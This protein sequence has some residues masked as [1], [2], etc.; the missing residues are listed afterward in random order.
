[1]WGRPPRPGFTGTRPPG[2]CPAS[3]D[4]RPPKPRPT[5]TPDPTQ[6]T[7]LHT[8]TEVCTKPSES[9]AALL[10][11][12]L[13]VA[14]GPATLNGIELTDYDPDD[15]RRVARAARRTRTSSTPPSVRTC[16]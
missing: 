14:E 15:V 9:L 8:E 12:F 16:V 10:F 11:R 1:M 3:A 4:A 6:Q 7:P 5:T 13:D 2:L